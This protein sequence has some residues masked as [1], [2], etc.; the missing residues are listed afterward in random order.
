M[1]ITNDPCPDGLHYWFAYGFETPY[2]FESI[3]A[4]TSNYDSSCAINRGTDGSKAFFGVNQFTSLPVKERA[5]QLGTS[6]M[7]EER[8][9]ACSK[10]QNNQPVSVILVDFA[11]ATDLLQVTQKHN[12]KLARRLL[13]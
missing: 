4:I 13:N 10:V 1:C 6:Q 11:E 5:S 2:D 7:L 12:S 9:S 3:E 8:L